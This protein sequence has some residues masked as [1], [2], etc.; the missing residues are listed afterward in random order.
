MVIQ[1]YRELA[2][3]RRL[4]VRVNEQCQLTDRDQLQQ[5]LEEGYTTNKGDS[6]FRIGPLKI[7]GDGSLGARTAYLL[8]SYA[9][10]PGQRGMEVC[11]YEKLEELITLAHT[12]GMQAAV[13]AIGDGCVEQ[14]L[15]AY[16]AVLKKDP[17]KDHRHGIV[18]CQIMRP[19][20]YERFRILGLHAYVQSIFLDYDIRIVKDRVGRV[21]AD[22]SYGGSCYP[23]MGISMSNGSD[24]PVEQPVPLRGIQCAVTRQNLSGTCMP[25]RPD[26]ALTVEQALDSYTVGGA[27]ASFE[28]D[29]KGDIREGM[30]ADFIILGENP[31]TVMPERLSQIPVLGTWLGGINVFMS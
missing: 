26:Q 28:E 10:A 29:V 17:R 7:I 11:S 19:D 25:Y 5:F 30:L 4:T 8:D 3:E 6:M 22:S 15:R 14:V 9:D 21:V 27:Y 13:H 24:A 16:E 18:H 12:H 1:A 2:E 31:F 20:Q 23:Q